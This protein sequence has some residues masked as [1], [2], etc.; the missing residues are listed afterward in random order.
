LYK[1][2]RYGGP[3]QQDIEAVLWNNNDETTQELMDNHP[4][5]YE[6]L[7]Q[8]HLSPFNASSIKLTGVFAIFFVQNTEKMV[9][10][11]NS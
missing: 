7:L 6:K 4:Y 2:Q 9:V 1:I 5:A 3:Q 8:H 11:N 10:R